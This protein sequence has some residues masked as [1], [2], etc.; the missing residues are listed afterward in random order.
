[1]LLKGFLA[2]LLAVLALGGCAPKEPA[3]APDP[4]SIVSPFDPPPISGHGALE[5]LPV[6][7]VGSEEIAPSAYSD[8]VGDGGETPGWEPDSQPFALTTTTRR[9]GTRRA[10]R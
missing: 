3:S 1:M 7:R 9:M 4:S 6:M 5:D 2:L 10:S 8:A